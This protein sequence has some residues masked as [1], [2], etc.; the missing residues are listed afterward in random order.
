MPLCLLSRRE[1]LALTS[2]QARITVEDLDAW[3]RGAPAAS[4]VAPALDSP[5]WRTLKLFSLNDYMGLS[6]HPEVRRATAQAAA[7]HG[8]GEPRRQRQ[9]AAVLLGA[10]QLRSGGRAAGLK[11]YLCE[12]DTAPTS[13]DHCICKPGSLRCEPGAP[14]LPRR[15]AVVGARRRLLMAAPGAGGRASR[16][17]RSALS[18][19]SSHASS[20]SLPSWEP[21]LPLASPEAYSGISS[22]ASFLLFAFFC[23]DARPGL[24]WDRGPLDPPAS[25]HPPRR[26]QAPR[27]ACS[28]RPASPPTWRQCLLCAWVVTWQCSATSS[29]MPRWSMARGWGAAAARRCTCTL[30]TTWRSLTTC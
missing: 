23:M 25:P 28:S 22:V 3:A 5:Q 11:R 26:L 8:M 30:T 6:S 18:A 16:A 10:A 12:P 21:R 7:A 14:P 27:S 4:A 2:A 9:E 19:P 24:V 1:A 15:H 29:T 17:Q 20:L 13:P